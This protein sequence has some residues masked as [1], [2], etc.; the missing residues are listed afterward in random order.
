[1][2]LTSV[3]ASDRKKTLLQ[4]SSLT[5]LERE[6]YEGEVQRYRNTDYNPIMMIT[7]LSV[8]MTI[9]VNLCVSH[10]D[11]ISDKQNYGL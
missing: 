3:R 7:A 9:I 5:L 4:Y 8:A 10:F 1:M 11:N 6:C 2:W